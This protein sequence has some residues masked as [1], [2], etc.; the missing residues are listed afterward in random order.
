MRACDACG[1]TAGRTWG[2]ASVLTSVIRCSWGCGRPGTGHEFCGEWF[3]VDL[4]TSEQSPQ[5]NDGYT[6]DA[7]L[8]T[9]H[10]RHRPVHRGSD[11]F[12]GQA[13]SFTRVTQ[14]CLKPLRECRNRKI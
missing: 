2:D 12:L 4:V 11:L 5:V 9:P 7:R 14:F 13:G 6:H 10:F 8:D 3:I 1:G